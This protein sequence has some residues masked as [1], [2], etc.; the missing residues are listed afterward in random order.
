MLA[1]CFPEPSW[2]V[3]WFLLSPQHAGAPGEGGVAQMRDALI[4]SSFGDGSHV[5]V[6]V[7][8]VSERDVVAA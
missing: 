6:V 5:T 3:T 1:C 2:I 4:T 7:L 8:W